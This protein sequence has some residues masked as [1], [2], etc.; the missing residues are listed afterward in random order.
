MA[1]V[2]FFMLQF[3]PQFEWMPL[4]PKFDPLV[5]IFIPV[6][7]YFLYVFNQVLI[8]HSCH[9]ILHHLLSYSAWNLLPSGTHCLLSLFLFLGIYSHL[10]IQIP[11]IMICYVITHHPKWM[12]HPPWIWIWMKVMLSVCGNLTIQRLLNPPNFSINQF[13]LIFLTFMIYVTQYNVN[14]VE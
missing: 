3:F 12:L 13:H 14:M 8:C 4:T 7:S 9:R 6:M 11:W 1:L 5:D 10:I 2:L